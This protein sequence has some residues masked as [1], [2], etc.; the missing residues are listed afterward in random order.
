MIRNK[1]NYN[2]I[3][4]KVQQLGW[5][6]MIKWWNKLWDYFSKNE[7]VLF[8]AQKFKFFLALD[9]KNSNIFSEKIEKKN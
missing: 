8:L 2:S 1:K 9:V 6:V 5:F 4:P 3:A 7:I